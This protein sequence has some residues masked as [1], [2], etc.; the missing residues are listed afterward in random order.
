MSDLPSIQAV[1][2]IDEG[3]LIV[4]AWITQQ[5][6]DVGFYKLLAKM[7]KDGTCE[8]VHFVQRLNGEKDTFYRGDVANEKELH[9]V[10]ESIN[11]TLA[12]VFGNACKLKPGSSE[13]YSLSGQQLGNSTTH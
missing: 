4:S 12:R 13:M 9:I 10:V 3:E 6:P 5:I 11:H 2:N 1:M 8:W 7:K